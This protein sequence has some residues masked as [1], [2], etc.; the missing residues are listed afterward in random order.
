MNLI[1][2]GSLRGQYRLEIT[3]PILHASNW[4]TWFSEIGSLAMDSYIYNRCGG[5]VHFGA[6]DLS[7]YEMNKLMVYCHNWQNYFGSL[8]PYREM[9]DEYDHSGRPIRLPPA[10]GVVYKS[11]E[12]MIYGLYRPLRLEGGRFEPIRLRGQRR[13]NDQGQGR[14]RGPICR[15]H[16]LNVH[17]YF[18]QRTIEVRLHGATLNMKVMAMWI[19][20]WL[21]LF[22]MVPNMS[23]EDLRRYSPDKILPKRIVLYYEKLS[24]ARREATGLQKGVMLTKVIKKKNQNKVRD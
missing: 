20:M 5:H 15:Y 16:W 18:N 22:D 2:D 4:A 1:N 12:D 3:S 6:E 13:A 9:L 21:H 24:K 19:D 10:Y 7:W 8:C 17:S 14:F 11:K 23:V